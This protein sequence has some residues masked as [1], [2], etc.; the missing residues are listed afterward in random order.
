MDL[1]DIAKREYKPNIASLNLHRVVWWT[2]Y[3]Y[4]APQIT[5][6]YL[7][8]RMFPFIEKWMNTNT[9]G[10]FL[11]F[12]PPHL[13]SPASS[14]LWRGNWPQRVILKLVSIPKVRGARRKEACQ[15]SYEL[16]FTEH[17]L[18]VKAVWHTIGIC[19]QWREQ[20]KRQHMD[21]NTGNDA[22]PCTRQEWGSVRNRIFQLFVP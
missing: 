18:R 22:I 20:D 8:H 3:T 17:P 21:S 15:R 5:E 1:L 10:S 13:L 11:Y 16:E 6:P 2:S 14:W 19:N 7:K 9:W 12:E 4:K